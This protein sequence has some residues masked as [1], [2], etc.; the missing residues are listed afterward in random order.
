LKGE[1]SVDYIS[2][3]DGKTLLINPS[4]SLDYDSIY[5]IVISTEAIKDRASQHMNKE[6][7][8]EFKTSTSPTNR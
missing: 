3:I 4:K 2:N 7:V 8:L 5:K 6:Y 1:A